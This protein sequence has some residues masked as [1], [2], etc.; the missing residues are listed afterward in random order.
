MAFYR[1]VL[2]TRPNTQ[3]AIPNVTPM[4]FE[5]VLRYSSE[6]NATPVTDLLGLGLLMRCAVFFYI[7]GFFS[8]ILVFFLADILLNVAPRRLPSLEPTAL[9]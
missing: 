6:C 1:T 8:A 3:Y 5:T 2:P 7:L 4:F 9:E